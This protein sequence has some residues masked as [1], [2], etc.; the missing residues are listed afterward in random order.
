MNV[1]IFRQDEKA[2]DGFA[3]A[4]VMPLA[5][6]FEAHP[7]MAQQHRDLAASLIAQNLE[8]VGR[9]ARGQFFKL[10]RVG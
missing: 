7:E 6:Y 2:P 3:D 8:Y 5:G 10:E 1:R 9:N 4:G